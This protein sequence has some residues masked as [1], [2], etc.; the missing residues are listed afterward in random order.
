[1]T[2]DDKVAF[3]DSTK[4]ALEKARADMQA[5]IAAAGGMERVMATGGMAADGRAAAAARAVR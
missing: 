1:M 4:T 5:R 2:D 3:L